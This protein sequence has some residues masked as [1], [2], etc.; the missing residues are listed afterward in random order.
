V[1]HD[2]ATLV[3]QLLEVAVGQ[4]VAQVPAHRDRDDLS[5]E[6][7]TSGRRRQGPTSS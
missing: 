3:Q 4:A 1:I 6:A 5:W 7:V 2:D